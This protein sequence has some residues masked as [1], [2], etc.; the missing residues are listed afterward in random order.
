MKTDDYELEAPTGW[1]WIGGCFVGALLGA[2]G[3]PL[4]FLLLL[5]AL[6]LLAP[7]GDAQGALFWSLVSVPLGA[8]AGAIGFPPARLL[9]VVVRAKIRR[10]RKIRR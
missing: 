9:F 7:G 1:Q 2:V 10:G 4:A 6:A 8:I 3:A 5:C